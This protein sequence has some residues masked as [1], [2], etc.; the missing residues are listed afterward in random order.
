M[1][2]N[3]SHLFQKRDCFVVFTSPVLSEE[4]KELNV[5]QCFPLDFCLCRVQ[6]LYF[7]D[8]NSVLPQGIRNTLIRISAQSLKKYAFDFIDPRAT[9]F[10]LQTS[11]L[12]LDTSQRDFAS[13]GGPLDFLQLRYSSPIALFLLDH[14]L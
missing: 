6:Q 2:R 10:E 9:R 5:L 8:K 4:Y 13:F 14:S 1:L 3:H 7:E 11:E 12:S